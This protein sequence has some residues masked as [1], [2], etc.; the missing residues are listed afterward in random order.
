MADGRLAGQA[1]YGRPAGKMVADESLAPFGVKSRSVECDNARRLLSAVLKGVQA[2]R[3]DRRGIGMAE[4]AENAA[5]LVQPVFIEIDAG[6]GA[7][8]A[9][10]AGRRENHCFGTAAGAAGAGKGTFLLMIASSFCLSR[11]EL[12]AV[13]ASAFFWPGGA[14]AGAAGLVVSGAADSSLGSSFVGRMFPRDLIQASMVDAASSGSRA[15]ILSAVSVSTGRVLAFFT[16]SGCCLSDTSQLKIANATTAR[17]KPR[18]TPNTRPR[19]R[20]R[21]PILLSRIASDSRTV[22]NDTTISVA[23]N[24]IAAAIACATMSLWI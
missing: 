17:R 22:T 15:T 19:V 3:D 20:S 11:V 9:G 16:H 14:A 2:E 18:A 1:I 7:R 23:K 12:G 5:F 8:L 24:T 13:A 6:G 4:D 10:G 21:A